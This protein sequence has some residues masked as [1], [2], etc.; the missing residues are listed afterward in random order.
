MTSAG[1]A[2]THHEG[3]VAKDHALQHNGAYYSGAAFHGGNHI[4]YH[5][6]GS[7]IP[8]SYASASSAAPQRNKPF[9]VVQVAIEI[10]HYLQCAEQAA[11]V[12]SKSSAKSGEELEK[13]CAKVRQSQVSFDSLAAENGGTRDVRDLAKAATPGLK[14]ADGLAAVLDDATTRS[15][16]GTRHRFLAKSKPIPGLEKFTRQIAGAQKEL[17]KQVYSIVRQASSMPSIRD[18]LFGLS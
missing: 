17:L 5:A 2:E 13:A 9:H 6:D 12:L 14:A 11:E 18:A 4:H 3:A 1:V 16:K 15:A 10:A 8:R 7:S